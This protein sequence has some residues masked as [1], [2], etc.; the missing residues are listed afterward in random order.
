MEFEYSISEIDSFFTSFLGKNNSHS[1]Q[2]Q[3]QDKFIELHAAKTRKITIEEMFMLEE[4][5]QLLNQIKN[6]VG[7]RHNL[8]TTKETE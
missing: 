2:A 6:S 1:A 7:S 5:N 3:L 8:Q 4:Q